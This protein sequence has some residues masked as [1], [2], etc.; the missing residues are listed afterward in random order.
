[1]VG[2]VELADGP[3]GAERLADVL[4]FVGEFGAVAFDFEAV[5]ESLSGGVD[6]AVEVGD[7]AFGGVERPRRCRDRALRG[8]DR[9]L[10]EPAA[11]GA[12]VAVEVVAGFGDLGLSVVHGRVEAGSFGGHGGDALLG[13]AAPVGGDPAVF[14]GAA[15][16]AFTL[17]GGPEFGRVEQARAVGIVAALDVVAR[18]VWRVLG[19]LRG[20]VGRST[21]GRR[22][23]R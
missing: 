1:M 16:V 13:V 15:Q 2:D 3:V 5:G 19:G 9:A 23:R 12:V 18:L 10:V 8:L 17:E 11:E 21:C 6:L 4:V 14:E 20:R 22:P 7:A